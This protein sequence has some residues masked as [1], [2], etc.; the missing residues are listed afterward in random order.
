[1]T[2]AILRGSGGR[3]HEVVFGSSPLRV[4]VYAGEETV[5]IHIEADFDI[6]P[7]DRRRFTIVSMSRQQFSETTGPAARKAAPNKNFLR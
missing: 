2:H 4:D 6:L 3:S 1:M 5:E 7:G